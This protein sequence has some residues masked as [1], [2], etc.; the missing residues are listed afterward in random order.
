MFKVGDRVRLVTPDTYFTFGLQVGSVYVVDRLDDECLRLVG[1]GRGPNQS[2]FEL[3]KL[4]NED[5]VAK[6]MKELQDV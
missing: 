3:A 2:R 6:R 1:Y 4:S 5:R